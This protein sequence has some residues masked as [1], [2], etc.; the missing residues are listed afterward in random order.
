MQIPQTLFVGGQKWRVVFKPLAE[1]DAACN[2]GWCL[3]E[4][5]IIFIANDI[6]QDRQEEIFLHELLH[7]INIYLSEKETEYLAA[8][9][10]QVLKQ[11][12]LNFAELSKGGFSVLSL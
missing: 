3:W 8:A 5:N 1:I 4:K 12:N 2:G 10:Y 9:L 11:N 7:A 6:P